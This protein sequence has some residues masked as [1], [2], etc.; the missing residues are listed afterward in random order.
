VKKKTCFTFALKYE[1]TFSSIQYIIHTHT[2]CLII[3][4][5]M[6]IKRNRKV[7]YYF[8]I[9]ATINEKLVKIQMQARDKIWSAVMI[10]RRR[11]LF[12]TS[13]NNYTW[14]ARDGDPVSVENNSPRSLTDGWSYL[15][16]CL[17]LAIG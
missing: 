9:F 3:L 12:S 17:Y 15:I 16:I 14:T 4:A 1:E 6:H 5:R 8:E 7:L 2:G 11:E 13:G 10:A